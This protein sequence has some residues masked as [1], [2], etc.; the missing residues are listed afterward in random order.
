MCWCVLLAWFWVQITAFVA[1][2]SCQ[3]TVS[4]ARLFVSDRFAKESIRICSSQS[5]AEKKT[6]NNW[7]MFLGDWVPPAEPRPSATWCDHLWALAPK[8]SRGKRCEECPSSF[9]EALLTPICFFLGL[10]NPFILG[11]Y[12]GAIYQ[13][14]RVLSALVSAASSWYLSRVG[15][16]RTE[17]R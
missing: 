10:C 11:V 14:R 9:W 15:A 6:Q 12:W 17:S 8:P 1:R 7:C 13:G 4:I 2:R 16:M 5:T 3:T